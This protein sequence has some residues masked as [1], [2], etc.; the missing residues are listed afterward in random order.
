MLTHF[1]DK[2]KKRIQKN[3]INEKKTR[4]REVK[5]FK[6]TSKLINRND[7][8]LAENKKSTMQTIAY[9]TQQSHIKDSH[10]IIF[11]LIL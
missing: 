4:Q 6:G 2:Y 8:T 10:L 7:N 5:N 1:K 9:K 3:N 11:Y